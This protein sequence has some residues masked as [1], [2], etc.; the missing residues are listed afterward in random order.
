MK[1][2]EEVMEDWEKT[3]ER[4]AKRYEE[5]PIEEK[6][7]RSVIADCRYMDKADIYDWIASDEIER[8]KQ[9]EEIQRL[10]NIINE[11]THYLETEINFQKIID[12]HHELRKALIKLEELKEGK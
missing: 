2:T 8:Y 6:I 10:N 11:F 12:R 3:M 9:K 4:F 7:K 1:S 5:V